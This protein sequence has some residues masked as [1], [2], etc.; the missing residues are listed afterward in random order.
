M[1][2]KGRTNKHITT[3]H[4]SPGYKVAKVV[5]PEKSFQ[6]RKRAASGDTEFKDSVTERVQICVENLQGDLV[7]LYILKMS[8]D[9]YEEEGYTG[10]IFSRQNDIHEMASTWGIS[11]IGYRRGPSGR[12]L[13]GKAP[14]HI[15]PGKKNWPWRA[16]IAHTETFENQKEWLE[17]ICDRLNKL[18]TTSPHFHFGS[19][20][21][22]LNICNSEQNEEKRRLQDVLSDGSVMEY[23]VGYYDLCNPSVSEI[24]LKDGF[25]T[26]GV[27][28]E[29]IFS[30]KK[31]EAIEKLK[32]YVSIRIPKDEE[33]DDEA[34]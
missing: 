23:L 17:D 29:T 25:H 28:I 6:A 3:K 32:S 2:P 15:G 20:P 33:K 27:P 19:P 13:M 24:A 8:K 16:M 1:P 30:E 9:G 5:S 21:F 34:N 10:P 26:V 11:Y 12:W 7:C 4:K 14:H 31:E 22:V 18:R